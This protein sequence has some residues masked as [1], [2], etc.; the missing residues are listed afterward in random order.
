MMKELKEK[1]LQETELKEKELKK[2]TPENVL[3][4]GAEQDKNGVNVPV[5]W[6]FN[7][8]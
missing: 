4:C 2:Y 7:V 1:E 8:F 5:E 6:Y 3:R